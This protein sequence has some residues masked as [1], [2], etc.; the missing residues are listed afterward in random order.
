MSRRYLERMSARISAGANGLVRLWKAKYGLV[1]SGTFNAGLD[2][3]LAT[4]VS[5]FELR[6]LV[7][8]VLNLVF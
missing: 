6:E 3:H 5:R 8:G 2:I 4:M 7:S 1:G